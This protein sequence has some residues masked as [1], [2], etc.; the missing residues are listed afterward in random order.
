MTIRWMSE[1][2]LDEVVAI[3][4]L[5]FANSAFSDPQAL[6]EFLAQPLNAG[7]V[8]ASRWLQRTLAYALYTV[9]TDEAH[10]LIL[11]EIATHPKEQRKGFAL[12]LVTWIKSR[13]FHHNIQVNTLD[14][15]LPMHLLL[16]KA[17]FKATNIKHGTPNDVY[18]FILQQCQEVPF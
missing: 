15:Q 4:K 8:L 10:P 13:C 6:R 2:D 17:G 5:V 16:K 18:T 1:A 14:T 11:R 7:I 3:N 9:P 12:K